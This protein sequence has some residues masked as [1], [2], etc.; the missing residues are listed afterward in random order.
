MNQFTSEDIRKRVDERKERIGKKEQW[1]MDMEPDDPS[2]LSLINSIYSAHESIGVFLAFLGQTVEAREWFEKAANYADR[3]A[4]STENLW[5]SAD[6]DYKDLLPRM[7]F[8]GLISAIISAD[9]Q[10]IIQI[11][12]TTLDMDERF[13]KEFALQ[14]VYYTP[15]A[16][17]AVCLDTEQVDDFIECARN[18]EGGTDRF[19]ARLSAIETI[20]SQ[21]DSGVEAAVEQLLNIHKTNRSNNLSDPNSIMSYDATAFVILAR[22]RGLNVQVQS[23]YI[24]SALVDYDSG[25]NSIPTE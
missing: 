17:A 16:L 18:E 1:L 10:Q 6:L 23:P 13:L 25:P 4:K 20:S 5:H 22:Q 3:Y 21:D 24:P 7:L 12:R 11:S 8:G 14:R 15:K 9:Q 2:I 19:L